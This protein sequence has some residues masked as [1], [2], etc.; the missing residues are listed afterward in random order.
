[1]FVV[2]SSI[3]DSGRRKSPSHPSRLPG[4]CGKSPVATRRGTSMSSRY[5]W[6][7]RRRSHI[8][9]R[10]L[11]RLRVELVNHSKRFTIVESRTASLEILLIRN[12]NLV[13]I[14]LQNI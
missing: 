7:N 11:R 5:R 10:G 6:Y 9:L 3:A 12:S 13:E 8:E 1:M 14:Y 2:A 4:R